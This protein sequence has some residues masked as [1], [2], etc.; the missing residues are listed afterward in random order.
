MT[1]SEQAISHSIFLSKLS[2]EIE[3]VL[4]DMDGVLVDS[5]PLHVQAW[6]STMTDYGLPPL[7]H[8]AYINALGR[9]N[10]DMIARFLDRQS[11]E[12]PLETRREI[13]NLKEDL[14]RSKIRAEAK[15]MPGRF[16]AFQLRHRRRGLRLAR[17]R[18]G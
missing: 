9:T 7:D 18:C 14:F 10:M 17:G 11:I 3:A 2:G 4:F 8:A 15:I 5:I 16:L 1:I 13:V 12:L 6:N